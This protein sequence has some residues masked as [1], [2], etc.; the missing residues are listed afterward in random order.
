[1]RIQ[2]LEAGEAERACSQFDRA[3]EA[4][5]RQFHG[6]QI[7]DPA[8]YHVALDSTSIGFDACVEIITRAAES[9]SPAAA[10]TSGNGAGS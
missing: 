6:V 2:G 5:F 10:D 7:Q 8:L 9:L 3:H 1:V 4:Y